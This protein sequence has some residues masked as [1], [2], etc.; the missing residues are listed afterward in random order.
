MDVYL[1]WRL[2]GVQDIYSGSDTQ[3]PDEPSFEA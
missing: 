2:L 3:R 1:A